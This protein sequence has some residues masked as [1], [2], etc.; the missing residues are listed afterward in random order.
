MTQ[1]IINTNG[2]ISRQVQSITRRQFLNSIGIVSGGLVLGGIAVGN[3]GPFANI[4][5]T[6]N[7]QSK[8]PAFNLFVHIAENSQVTILCHRSEMGQGIRTGLPQIVADELQADWSK[9]HVEQALANAEYGDQNTDGSRSVRNFYTVMR[10]MG[11]TARMMLEQAAANR[12]Q[13]PVDEVVAREH[14]V[15]HQTSGRALS[16]GELALDAAALPTPAK[17]TL[18]LKSVEQFNLIGK[19]VAIVD[20]DDMVTGN[21]V[22]G[23]DVQLPNM[24]YA[25]I[26]RWPV[27]GAKLKKVDDSQARKVRGVEDIIRMPA[28]RRPVKFKAQSGVAVLASNSWAALKGRE[29][30]QLEWRDGA[31]GEHDSVEFS[32]EMVEKVKTKGSIARERGDFYKQIELSAQ[33]VE[34]VY[35][36]P[37]QPHQP[38]EPPAAT[39]WFHDGIMEV[40]ACVQNPQSA[41]DEVASLLGLAKSKVVLHVTLLGGAFGRKSK[42][43]FVCEAAYLAHKSRRPVKVFWS[44]ED[45]IKHDYYHA[46][47]AQYYQAGLDAAG[48]VSAWLQRTSFPTIAS[49][50][51]RM[52]WWP[53]AG[54]L[55]QGFVDAPIDTQHQS[56]ESHSADAH[57]RIGW[58][59]SVANIHHGFGL[60]SFVDE[61][62]EA[63]D[64]RVTDMWRE[65]LGNNS[66][67]MPADD[68]ADYENYGES[69]GRYPIEVK[70]FKYLIDVI[71]KS[72]D[73]YAKL[74]KGQGW[75]F[76]M[77]RSFAS[78]VAVA[79]RV[80]IIEDVVKVLDMH[81]AID[82]GLVV[83]PD[84]VKAQ[85]EG[86]MVFGLT[87]ALMGGVS[88][89]QGRIEQSNFD[90]APITG[91]QQCPPMMVHIVSG[92]DEL[93]GGVGEP[94]VPPVA[95]SVTNAIFAASGQRIRDLPVNQFFEV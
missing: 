11:A 42:A 86:A 83:N 25:S 24:L 46:I 13:V 58:M 87:I 29:K 28:Q 81:A 76:S 22:Y 3:E 41:R 79:T 63:K 18:V 8:G 95:A 73:M 19:P 55:S 78:Y 44:R 51:T 20:M 27:V 50:F 43:D 69:L 82:C 57:V 40:W 21:T 59:R 70:R 64:I 89:K 66:T 17:E 12:W 4:A 6:G 49:T 56:F 10:D 26:S 14:A 85:I 60:G 45:D 65:L 75:G 37:Y 72:T 15:H 61:V 67:V 34:A 94:G 31:S 16:F 7:E 23:Q 54:E 35:T 71:E 36:V 32:R 2:R 77:H 92:Q 88:V 91:M 74:P 30:L 53:M 5:L 52:I 48:N 68:G 33:S 9:V 62:A 90:D 47:S 80:E 1:D 84:R 93:P 38:M 39:A